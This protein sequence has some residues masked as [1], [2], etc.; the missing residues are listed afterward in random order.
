[1]F[2]AKIKPSLSSL[3]SLS[4]APTEGQ[5][6]FIIEFKM[7]FNDPCNMYYNFLTIPSFSPP[8]FLLPYRDK[9]PDTL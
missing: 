4:N 6:L 5:I 9:T 2:L 3:S 8:Y 1:M 7:E